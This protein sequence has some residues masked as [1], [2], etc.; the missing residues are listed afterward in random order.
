VSPPDHSYLSQRAFARLVGCSHQLVTRLVK[1]GRLPVNSDGALP[2]PA[3]LDAYQARAIAKGGNSPATHQAATGGNTAS[4]ATPAP[5][6]PTAETTSPPKLRSVPLEPDPD[7]DDPD[8]RLAG[9]DDKAYEDRLRTIN[10]LLILGGRWKTRYALT[11]GEVLGKGSNM[12]KRQANRLIRKV[13]DRRISERSEQTK[14]D[15]LA[16]LNARLEYCQGAAIEA[17]QYGAAVTAITRK[18]ELDGY[19]GKLQVLVNNTTTN[20]NLTV[21]VPPTMAELL[22]DMRELS[23]DEGSALYKL[24]ERSTLATGDAGT[25]R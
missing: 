2:M 22:S 9:T 6:K 11:H 16:E 1:Q 25:N 14:A 13:L 10:M 7:E 17:G 4:T 24:A 20:N 15:D 12:S 23:D 18:A 19:L 3:A 21:V 8:A 5:A